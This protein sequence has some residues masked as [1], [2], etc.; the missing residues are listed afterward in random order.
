[1][2]IMAKEHVNTKDKIKYV[3]CSLG[4]NILLVTKKSVI[5][6]ILHKTVKH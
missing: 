5:K 6:Q 2:R 3:V 4:T 1:M